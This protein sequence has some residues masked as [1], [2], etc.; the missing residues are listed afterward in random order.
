MEN[1]AELLNKEE[2]IIKICQMQHKIYV[3]QLIEQVNSLKHG[4][5]EKLYLKRIEMKP[6]LDMMESFGEDVVSL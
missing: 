6:L 2:K 5:E 3:N 1:Q 4:C